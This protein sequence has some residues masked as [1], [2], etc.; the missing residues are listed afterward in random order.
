MPSDWPDRRLRWLATRP[1]SEIAEAYRALRTS[2][3]L[4]KTGRSAKVLMVT[5][6]FPQEGKTTTSVNL[7]IVLAQQGARVLLIEADMRRAGIS[8]VASAQLGYWAQYNIGSKTTLLILEEAIYLCQTSRISRCCPRVRLR[9][10]LPR[11]CPR[12]A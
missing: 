8:T 3:L 5:S 10:T 7:A 4:S 12:R 6:A 9:C 11:C 1:K 2:I